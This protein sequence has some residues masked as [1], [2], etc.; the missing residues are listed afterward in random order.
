M[1][2]Q[3]INRALDWLEANPDNHI[4]GMMASIDGEIATHPTD[5]N[6][7][8]WCALGRIAYEL[9]LE[10]PDP[11]NGELTDPYTELDKYLGDDLCLAIQ[12]INDNHDYSKYHRIENIRYLVETV[13]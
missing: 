1:D 9:N 8:C 10:S 2:E 3:L 6:A 13:K 4:I 11:A 7:T 5:P 12:R